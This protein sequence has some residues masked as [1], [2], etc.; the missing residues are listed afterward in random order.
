[1]NISFDKK[2]ILFL[3][4]CFFIYFQGLLKLP[5]MDRDEARFATATKTMLINKE[6]IDIKMVD[7]VRYKK[8]IGIYWSQALMNSIIGKYPYDEIWIY[9]L[10]SILGVFICLI[11]IYFSIKRLENKQIAFFS[12]F[13]LIFSILTISEIHQSK[14]DGLLFL[15][16]SLCNLKIYKLIT[17]KKL[18]NFDIISFW[19]FLA[20]GIL[21]K[22][23]IIFLFTVLPMLI[24]SVY[25]KI[26]LFKLVW[27]V[28]GLSALIIISLPWFILINIK[29][30]GL[31]W[32]ESIGHDLFSKVK[33][34]Q[35][36][37]GFPPGYYTI[38][39]FIFFWPGSVFLFNFI[40]EIKLDFKKICMN[41]FSF[42]LLVSFISPFIIFEIV[43][44]KLPH[45]VYP[46]YLPLS[47]MIS[48]L[49]LRN[50][51]KNK[52][53]NFAIIPLLIFPLL[54]I[55]L[56]IFVTLE[57]SDPDLIMFLTL[58][59]LISLTICLVLSKIRQNI[60]FLVIFS[61]LFQFFTFFSLI[62]ILIPKLDEFWISDKINNI[63][64]KH[65]DNVSE[66]FSIG[67]NEPSLLF[68]TSHKVKYKLEDFNFKKDNNESK[69]LL[70]ITEQVY[71]K[72]KKENYLKNLTLIREFRGF[73]YSKGKNVNFKVFKN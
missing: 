62:Y 72:L 57:Y 16:I 11:A 24:F 27:S 48:K 26:N 66:I 56:I 2:I 64:T 68:L 51:F 52:L 55:S 6:Y 34:G 35:E 67:F 58:F 3:L 30:G 69:V 1:M 28:T 37:H 33:S 46:C 44:T 42:Y 8:P 73:N 60:K 17:Y 18:S 25:K 59:A 5:V 29:S 41:N 15:F 65:E 61:G 12:I 22:G 4:V 21:L 13:F 50:D 38:L 9:R 40:K 39:L 7:E 10:P 31:F 53:S 20:F 70:I 71:N 19:I 23:P 54:V 47:I 36:S 32:S 14:T 45:Y 43:P 49:I 63:I